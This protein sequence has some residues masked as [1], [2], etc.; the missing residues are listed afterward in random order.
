[1]IAKRNNW[2]I[3]HRFSISECLYFLHASFWNTRSPIC[4]L[5][6][7][8]FHLNMILTTDITVDSCTWYIWY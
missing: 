3:N 7:C 4:C 1:L 6:D 5:G 2:V 8:S